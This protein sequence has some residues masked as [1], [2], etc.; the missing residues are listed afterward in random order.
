MNLKI[1]GIILIAVGVLLFVYKGITY[2]TREKV[3]DVGP[4]QVTQEKTQTFP[5]SPVLGGAALVGGIVLLGFSGKRV[6]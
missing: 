6:S 5:F 4:L 3:F 2:K 1:L